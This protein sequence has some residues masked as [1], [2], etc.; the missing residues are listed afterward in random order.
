MS[1]KYVTQ[2]SVG[3]Y[4][5]VWWSGK[6]GLVPTNSWPSWRCLYLRV[7][8]CVLGEILRITQANVRKKIHHTLGEW[9]DES[10]IISRSLI[11]IRIIDYLVKFSSVAKTIMRS[12]APSSISTIRRP[13]VVR[14]NAGGS[15][16]SCLV[17][18]SSGRLA[19]LC[20]WSDRSIDPSGCTKAASW[21]GNWFSSALYARLAVHSGLTSSFLLTAT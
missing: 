2:K 16:K 1:T 6:L 10:V 15:N 11:L 19:T 9:I 5:I 14:V 20:L 3:L 7:C 13:S 17:L 4:P 12:A 18:G 8:A 21:S